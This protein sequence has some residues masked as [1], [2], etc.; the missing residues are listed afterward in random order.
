VSPGEGRKVE[1]LKPMEKDQEGGTR[2]AGD[3]A[4]VLTRREDVGGMRNAEDIAGL[5]GT[6]CEASGR[7]RMG[8]AAARAKDDRKRGRHSRDMAITMYY[9]DVGIIDDTVA[10]RRRRR[11]EV[12]SGV[13]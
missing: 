3:D 4:D 13:E 5:F 1:P 12:T 8:G 9:V 10:R 2:S 11:R 7:E 6:S